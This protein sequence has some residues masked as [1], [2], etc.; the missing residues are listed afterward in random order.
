[1][2]PIINATPC[3]PHERQIMRCQACN[4]PAR[5]V[6]NVGRRNEFSAGKFREHTSSLF[7]CLDCGAA[8]SDSIWSAFAQIKDED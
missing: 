4:E 5:V 3:K 2:T 1:M 8:L 6:V 7:L